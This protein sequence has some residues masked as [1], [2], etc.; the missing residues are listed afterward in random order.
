MPPRKRKLTALD[1]FVDPIVPV[2]A[3]KYNAGDVQALMRGEA[4]KE[5]QQRFMQFL[6]MDV[7]GTYRMSFIPLS[8]RKSDFAEGK[9]FVG[10]QIV[11]LGKAN[12]A[13]MKETDDD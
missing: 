3:F 6:I 11:G 12:L 4:T 13:R 7:C 1:A 5:Q 10:N 9:R 8:R 2:T